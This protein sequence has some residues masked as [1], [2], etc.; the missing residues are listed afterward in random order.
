MTKKRLTD[1]W[2]SDIANWTTLNLIIAVTIAELYEFVATSDYLY[3]IA[4]ILAV[5]TAGIVAKMFFE[6]EKFLFHATRLIYKVDSSL[7]KSLFREQLS[8]RGLITMGAISL[9]LT[10]FF[11]G[12]S[13]I[14]TV[15]A[16]IASILFL[17]T[18]IIIAKRCYNSFKEI[19]KRIMQAF[20]PP[21]AEAVIGPTR[22]RNL[23]QLA[24]QLALELGEK[25]DKLI[26]DRVRQL[27]L[28]DEEIK[29]VIS[30]IM[31]EISTHYTEAETFDELVTL[32]MGD[33]EYD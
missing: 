27:H 6:D 29:E 21:A 17:S 30:Y 31:D 23:K 2:I 12:T 3:L 10:H 16:L 32:S 20:G 13:T 7:G 9:L 25:M 5:L 8:A 15:V 24:V 4:S 11:V 14:K 18:A 28:S 26:I 22:P 33:D 1:L 19:D